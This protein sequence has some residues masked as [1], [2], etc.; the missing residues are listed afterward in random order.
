M[1]IDH[2]DQFYRRNYGMLAIYLKFN[3]KKKYNNIKTYKYDEK[4]AIDDVILHQQNYEQYYK[5]INV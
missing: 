4:M 5:K 2:I 3:I 1:I